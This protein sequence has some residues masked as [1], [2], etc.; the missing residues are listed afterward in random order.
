MTFT[1]IKLPEDL[2]CQ[3]IFEQV[4]TGA[5]AQ[6]FERSFVAAQGCFYRSGELKCNAGHLI[7]D[8]LYSPLMEDEWASSVFDGTEEQI[9]VIQELQEL[10]DT[11][12]KM[13]AQEHR[14]R[15]ITFASVK[16][17]KISQF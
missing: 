10:H 6:N 4:Y 5:K 17:Y 2:T 3:Q 14:R 7:P 8:N 15:L 9:K 12:S 13:T 1:K 11:G 16:R